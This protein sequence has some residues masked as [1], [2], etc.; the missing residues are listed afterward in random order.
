MSND[1]MK[2][3]RHRANVEREI[4]LMKLMDHPNVIRLYDVWEGN[5]NLFVFLF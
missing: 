1:P 3:E 4:A 2:A 5:G